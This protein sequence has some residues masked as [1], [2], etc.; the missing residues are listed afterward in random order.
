MAGFGNRNLSDAPA[1][2][3]PHLMDLEQLTPT[4]RYY[5][6]SEVSRIFGLSVA[7]LR[8]WEEN[9]PSLKIQ[10][11][12]SGERVFQQKDLEHLR[13]IYE[14]V[15]E[16]RFTLEGARNYIKTKQHKQPESAEMLARLQ[17]C[18]GSWSNSGK[19]SWP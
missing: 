2:A 12:R 13:L 1:E 19:P 10:R 16:R 8:F 11:N 18:G 7:K 17:N 15:E 14:L 3:L 4:K 6:I 9:F 5:S